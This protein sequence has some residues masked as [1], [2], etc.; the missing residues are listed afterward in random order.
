[1]NVLRGEQWIERLT[2][3]CVDT[4]SPQQKGSKHPRKVSIRVK[5]RPWNI[6]E[7]QATTFYLKSDAKSK[8][9]KARPVPYSLKSA[10]ERELDRLLTCNLGILKP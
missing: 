9:G 5:G 2:L 1:M 8:Y 3:N 4:L 7:H 6:K 10:V